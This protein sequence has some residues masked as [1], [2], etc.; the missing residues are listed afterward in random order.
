MLAI[1]LWYLTFIM[2]SYIP[3]VPSLI[4]CSGYYGEWNLTNHLPSLALNRDPLDLSFP[5]S[6]GLQA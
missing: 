6:L 1:G 4:I 3:S 5:S 2:L